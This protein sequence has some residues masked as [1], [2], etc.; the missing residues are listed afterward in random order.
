MDVDLRNYVRGSIQTDSAY[1]TNIN[2]MKRITVIIMFASLLWGCTRE[3]DLP[4]SGTGEAEVVLQAAFSESPVS[5]SDDAEEQVIK[6]LDLL[7]LK[8]GEFRY[9]RKAFSSGNVYKATLKEDAG[10]TIHAFANCRSLLDGYSDLLIEGK[11]WDTEIRP[12]LITEN[13]ALA[14]E[15]SLLLP[16]WGTKERVDIVPDVINN[17]GTLWM[18]R[19]VAAAEVSVLTNSDEFLLT[20]ASLYFAATNGFLVPSPDKYNPDD[21]DS[22]EP[23][24]PLSMQTKGVRVAGN[25]SGNA[26]KHQ[27]YMFDNDTNET[28]GGNDKRY[29]RLVVGGRY[30]GGAITYYPLDFQQDGRLLR[31]TRNCKYRVNITKVN[32]PGYSTAEI[33]SEAEAVNMDFKVIEWNNFP[34]NNL[35][36]DGSD[37]IAIE[38]RTVVLEKYAGS[39]NSIPVS[40]SFKP[41]DISMEFENGQESIL[42][43]IR[44]DRF[45]VEMIVN[46]DGIYSFRV[47][48]LA[49]YSSFSPGDNVQV[50]RISA[51]RIQFDIT[52]VQTNY[53]S[54]DWANGG[55]E[56]I[57]G[58]S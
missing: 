9:R 35:Y 14:D 7:I 23:E 41:Q 12:Y 27:L 8:G 22:M 1:E 29:T 2:I 20:G 24:S 16:M 18:L 58:L 48:A 42:N 28:T 3:S 37:Y 19:S 39:S 25:V 31:V 57:E 46:G 6:E 34:E 21:P 51:K 45:E 11:N 55:N 33:A 49:D 44:N 43:G 4:V 38:N 5:R 17:I 56:D 36:I 52:I 26:I 30:N 15:G 54:G 40:S 53:N 50:L 13:P 10:I 47:T 32:G